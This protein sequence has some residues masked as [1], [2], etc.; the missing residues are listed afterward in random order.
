[1]EQ[2]SILAK[3][4]DD[5]MTK[6]LNEYLAAVDFSVEHRFSE[7]FERRMER[8]IKRREKPYYKLICTAGRRAVCIAAAVVIAFGFAMSFESVRAAVK[9][10]FT[11]VFS[12]HITLEVYPEFAEN[13]PDTIEEVYEITELPEGFELVDS[14]TCSTYAYADYVFEDYHID[15][16]QET[17][18]RFHISLDNEYSEPE[19]YVDQTGQE[20]WIQFHEGGNIYILWEMDGYIFVIDSN[21]DKDAVINLCMSTKLK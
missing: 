1:M 15:F 10:F 18:Q 2:Y 16:L 21:L 20:Y 9:E 14:E 11:K 19:V 13:D 7:K 6:E 17:K 12:D 8:L 5:V 4:L 3:A